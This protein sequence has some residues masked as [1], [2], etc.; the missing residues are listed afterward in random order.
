M[1]SLQLHF[2]NCKRAEVTLNKGNGEKY[3]CKKFAN[4]MKT[5]YSSLKV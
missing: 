1:S 5:K 3:S 2:S 4:Y